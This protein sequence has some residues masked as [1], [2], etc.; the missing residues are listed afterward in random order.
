MLKVK[1][2]Q[3]LIIF[4]NVA[5][6]IAGFMTVLD[7]NS[8]IKVTESNKPDNFFNRNAKTAA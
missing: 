4:V 1:Q 8:D 6:H 3:K 2:T 5:L 7:L